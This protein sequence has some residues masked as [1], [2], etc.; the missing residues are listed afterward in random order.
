MILDKLKLQYPDSIEWTAHGIPHHK[1]FWI[2]IENKKIGIPFTSLTI[3][4]EKLLSTLFDNTSMPIS[5]NISTSQLNWYHYFIEKEA[6]PLTSWKSIRLTYFTLSASNI[7]TSEIEE[8]LLSFFTDDSIL[9]WENEQNGFII[10]GQNLENI[11]FE[12]IKDIIGAIES[13]FYSKLQI[14]SGGFHEISDDLH[15][16]FTMEKN[17]FDIAKKAITTENTHSIKT[18][19]PFMLLM[20]IHSKKDWYIRELLGDM[21]TDTEMIKT[22]RTYLKLNR[23]ATLAA[24]ELFIHRNSLQYRVDKFIDKTNLDIKCFHDAMLAYICILF[25]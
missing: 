14:F 5:N 25:L 22:I 17:C 9:V 3:Q 12:A 4:E 24:K 23:N 16:H 7:S 21:A 10:E 13:D 18:V 2:T 11:N 20:G 15:E 8:A 1:Y 6:L 19:F